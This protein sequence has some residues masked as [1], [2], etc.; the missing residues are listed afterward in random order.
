V[1]ILLSYFGI[2]FK[3]EMT[4]KLAAFD[5]GWME[6]YAFQDTSSFQQKLD[7]R[8]LCWIYFPFRCSVG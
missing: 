2:D 3:T 6:R 4:S 1:H 8:L 7:F 5:T